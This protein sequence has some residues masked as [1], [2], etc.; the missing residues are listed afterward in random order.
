MIHVFQRSTRRRSSICCSV[1]MTWLSFILS[2]ALTLASPQFCF[3]ACSLSL[4]AKV[5]ESPFSDSNPATCHMVGSDAIEEMFGKE[6]DGIIDSRLEH[7]IASPIPLPCEGDGW[8]NVVD[9]NL[10]RDPSSECPGG[11]LKQN[12]SDYSLCQLELSDCKSQVYPTCTSY[13]QICGR[14][15]GYQIGQS[16]AF[17]NKTLDG[18]YLDGVSITRGNFTEHIWSFAAGHSAASPPASFEEDRVC[19][20]NN[21]NLALPQFIG[22]N[23]YCNSG[24]EA[25]SETTFPTVYSAN[26]LWD[27]QDCRS[28]AGSA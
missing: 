12:G 17:R 19:P 4:P 16:Q 10:E 18:A 6:L 1:E 7:F 25:P 26:P 23:F 21:E 15:K 20:C 28:S 14:V 27:S 9:F 2:C 24:A 3:A 22:D 11:W 13:S 8:V 5:L